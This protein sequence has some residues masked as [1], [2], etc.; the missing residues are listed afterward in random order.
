MPEP[1]IS[2]ESSQL[3]PASPLDTDGLEPRQLEIC[4]LLVEKG[5]MH[6]ERYLGTLRALEATGNPDRIPQASHSARE[7]MKGLEEDDPTFTP[8]LKSGALIEAVR[9]RAT[10]WRVLKQKEPWCKEEPWTG[11]ID[12]SLAVELKHVD[13]LLEQFGQPGGGNARVTAMINRLSPALGALPDAAAK[14]FKRDWK[15]ALKTFNDIAHHTYPAEEA[16]FREQITRL[17]ALLLVVLKPAP[18]VDMDELETLIAEGEEG[19]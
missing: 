15:G 8:V 17:E 12:G 4:S 2:N 5:A 18:L 10:S 11:Q 13:E 1:Q 6:A 19:L 3:T 16:D 7:L 14:D 9:A